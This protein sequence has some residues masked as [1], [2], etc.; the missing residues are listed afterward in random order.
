MAYSISFTLDMVAV[1]LTIAY[2]VS[3]LNHERWFTGPDPRREKRSL[4]NQKI[5]R[6]LAV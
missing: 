1:L 5:S 4:L 2:L 6:R 3:L